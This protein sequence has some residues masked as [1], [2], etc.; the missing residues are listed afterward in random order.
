MYKK[1]CP[2]HHSSTSPWHLLEP[3]LELLIYSV[4]PPILF[5]ARPWSELK[6]WCTFQKQLSL[7]S[8]VGL[9]VLAVSPTQALSTSIF[10][11]S[12]CRARNPV[13]KSSIPKCIWREPLTS[14]HCGNAQFNS[15]PFCRKYSAAF[16]A[17]ITQP[18][19]NPIDLIFSEYL[20]Q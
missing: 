11:R 19:I 8:T 16:A 13:R 5:C 2:D 3:K 6:S 7:C 9:V 17:S 15:T 12:Y 4:F 20:Q 1:S 10:S 14:I 18:P